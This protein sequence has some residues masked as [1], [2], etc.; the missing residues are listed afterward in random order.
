MGGLRGFMLA[1][2]SGARLLAGERRQRGYMNTKMSRR[3]LLAGIGYAAAGSTTAQLLRVAHAQ[4]AAQARQGQAG[5][6]CLSMIFESGSKAKFDSAKYVKK[7]LPLLREVYGD[8]VDRIELRTTAGSAMGIPSSVLATTTF[9][10]R[11]VT[12]FG[13]KLGANAARINED[14]DAVARGN[15]LVQPDRIVLGLGDARD[16]TPANSHVFSLYYRAFSGG[17]MGMMRGGPGGRPPGGPGPGGPAPGGPAPAQAEGQGQ[18]PAS[19]DPVFDERYF[20]DAFLPKLYSLYGSGAVRRLEGTIGMDQGGQKAAQ[21]AAYHITIRDRDAYDK[22]ARTAFGEL[23]KD[24]AKFM[25]NVL[26]VFADM[27]VTGI[28]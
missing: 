6:I 15:R 9:W 1:R 3:S 10:I 18:A 11:D 25:Q 8:S 5:G 22:E 21:L 7:H 19:K 14:L 27:R 20:V 24:S 16:D 28:A 4:E 23:Q 2:T 17:G 12:A 13:Q 26:P